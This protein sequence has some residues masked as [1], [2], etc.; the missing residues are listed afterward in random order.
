MPEDWT[1]D[2]EKI[3]WQHLCL[4]GFILILID[5]SHDILKLQL[6]DLPPAQ[7]TPKQT[8]LRDKLSFFLGLV[9][10]V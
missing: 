6:V 8:V 10:V 2:H 7:F 5:C 3:Q 4:R 9:N 1:M